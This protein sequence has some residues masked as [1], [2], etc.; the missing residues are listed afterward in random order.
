LFSGCFG[1]RPGGQVRR[2]P[3]D[4]YPGALRNALIVF[5]QR[6]SLIGLPLLTIGTGRP[7]GV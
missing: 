3:R 4:V 7:S 5:S 2:R 1:I 6:I